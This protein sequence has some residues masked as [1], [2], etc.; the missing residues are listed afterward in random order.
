MNDDYD[1][2]DQRYPSRFSQTDRGAVEA[3]L[4][5]GQSIGWTKIN[6]WVPGETQVLPGGAT[7]PGWRADA[8]LGDFRPQRSDVIPW[9]VT[10]RP[11]ALPIGGPLVIGGSIVPDDFPSTPAICHARITYG[12]GNATPDVVLVDWPAAGTSFVVHA[13]SIQVDLV[14]AALFSGMPV[15]ANNQ[16]INAPKAFAASICPARD[17]GRVVTQAPTY[18]VGLA[19]G[20]GNILPVTQF[21][22]ARKATAWALE[23][24]DYANGFPTVN[25]TL[26]DGNT[27]A[28]PRRVANYPSPPVSRVSRIPWW[29]QRWQLSAGNARG[30]PVDWV[31]LVQFLTL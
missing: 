4:G 23:G 11:Y 16:P 20:T 12:T 10:L 6:P 3:Q 8:T 19:A 28:T 14:A 5:R 25:V 9:N 2:D 22:V 7:L 15:D 18:T 30:V 17:F 24:I 13:Q 26:L 31:H 21:P 27:L 29:G 1:D